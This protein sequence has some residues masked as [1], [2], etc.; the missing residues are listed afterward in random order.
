M[1]F[2]L[3]LLAIRMT[4]DCADEETGQEAEMVEEQEAFLER[5]LE[6]QSHLTPQELLKKQQLEVNGPV[7]VNKDGSL[8][9]IA[10]WKELAA[11]ERE[12]AINAIARRNSKRLKEAERR[13]AEKPPPPPPP[14]PRRSWLQR[15]GGWFRGA[16]A[17]RDRRAR[18]EAGSN[19]T[20]AND[21]TDANATDANSASD[22]AQEGATKAAPGLLAS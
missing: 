13:E 18:P 14:P 5:E 9:R 8:G 22:A 19:A 12:A 10:N 3:V 2:A 1:R 16:F 7:V 4:A 20:D 11:T 6:E 21:A 17:R 15:V